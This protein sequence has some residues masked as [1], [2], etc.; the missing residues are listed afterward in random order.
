MK[1]IG[2]AKPIT[3]PIKTGLA[4]FASDGNLADLANLMKAFLQR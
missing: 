3:Y 4:K 1:T 2:A